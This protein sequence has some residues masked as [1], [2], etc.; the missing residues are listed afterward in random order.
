V[1]GFARR[2][3][4]LRRAARAFGGRCLRV[5]PE[6]KRDPDRIRA[7]AQQSHGAV[8]AAAHRDR[9]ASR[10]RRSRE[11]RADRVRQR[12]DDESLARHGSRFE[13]RQPY[14]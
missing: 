11:D 10:S 7:G 6:P 14:E 8:D 12:V 1:T 2:D 3:D 9:D 5:D 13:Q 4:G